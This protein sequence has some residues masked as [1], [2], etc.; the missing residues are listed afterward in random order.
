MSDVRLVLRQVA[1][2]NRSFWRNPAAAAFTFGF[3]VMFL[4]IFNTVFGGGTFEIAGRTTNLSTFY[5]PAIAAF[6][7]ISACFTNVA[8]GVT[9]S[10]DQGILKR[11]RGTPLPPWIYIAGRVLHS[12]AIGLLLVALVTAVGALVYDVDLPTG[13]LL[14]FVVA[15]VV[16]TG[17]FASLGMAITAVIP[18]AEAAPAI[19]NGTMLPLLFIS[20][21][22]FGPE[23]SPA[24]L[25][26]IA[27]LFPVRHFAE[28]LLAAFNPFETGPG[29]EWAHLGIVA[30]WGVVG[31]AVA[32]RFFTWEP[33]R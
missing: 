25:T 17:S 2:E 33:R 12:I 4:F 18:T 9:I 8:M 23:A 19:V 13:T 24:W 14:A 16:G 3:P 26:R 20:D 31:L 27:D 28:A 1:Y 11:T 15:L 5:I 29:F 7:V 30:A 6:S 21:I 32:V 10:R 22:F